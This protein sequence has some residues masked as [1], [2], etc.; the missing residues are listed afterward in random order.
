MG[1]ENRDAMVMD[2]QFAA[3][4]VAYEAYLAS[5]C[6]TCT[7]QAGSPYRVFGAS[8]KV[9]QGCV[10]ACHTEALRGILSESAFWHFRPE[11]KRVRAAMHKMQHKA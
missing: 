3:E 9:V 7:R 2:K 10:D 4:D 8:G 5:T 11:A 1:T 6:N